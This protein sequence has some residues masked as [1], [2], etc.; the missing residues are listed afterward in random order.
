[1]V[2][3]KHPVFHIII[4]LVL[5]ILCGYYFPVSIKIIASISIFLIVALSIIFQLTKK[6]SKYLSLFSIVTFIIFFTI[7]YTSINIKNDLNRKNHYT[8]FSEDG[9]FLLKVTNE[10]KQ[11]KYYDKY[12]AEII[13]INNKNSH[14]KI[15]LNIYKDSLSKRLNIDDEIITSGTLNEVNGVKN[16]FQFN[17]KKYLARKNIY[18]Q[19]TIKKEQYKVLKTEINSLNGYAHKIR[20]KISKS[21]KKSGFNS[22]TLSIINALLLGKRQEVSKEIIENYTKAGA[23]HILAISGLHIGIILLFLNFILKPIEKLKNGANIKLVLC[24]LLLWCFAFLAG[25]SASVV[26]AVTMFTAVAISYLGNRKTNVF[27]NLLVSIFF[28]LLFNPYY[29]FDVGFQLSYLAVFFI[30]W[31]QPILENLWQPKLK[32]VKYLWQ[33]VTVSTTAQMGVL[34]LSLYYFHQFPSL[35]FITNLVVIPFLGFIL[36]FGIIVIILSV[37]NIVPEFL[38]TG[39]E[40]IIQKMNLFIGWVAQQESFL[41]EN[42]SFSGYKMIASYLFLI[43]LVCFLKKKSLK[44]LQLALFSLLLIQTVFIY[45]KWKSNSSKEIV[46]FNKHNSTLIGKRNGNQLT[47][48]SNDSIHPTENTI[49]SYLT[50]SNIKSLTTKNNITSTLLLKHN[51]LIIDSL[52]IYK[53]SNLHPEKVLLIQS[54]KINLERLIKTINPKIIIADNSNY[55]SYINRWKNTCNKHKIPFYYTNYKGAYIIP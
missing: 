26:R 21:L 9:L 44:T 34:P 1:M 17:Y 20:N 53:I 13:Q 24:V 25:L 46:I 41:F 38:I 16:P 23:I 49:K 35:F 37:L 31:L 4:F 7:G 42:I 27:Q 33:I 50:G 48:F 40:F 36:S 47:L 22:K 6:N 51:T 12:E 2:F 3:S 30:V 14:G 54:P 5:G 52:G 43:S 39:Y 8:H 55:K 29:L 32:I 15:L 19:L 45:E 18:R 10:L 11:S 28:L